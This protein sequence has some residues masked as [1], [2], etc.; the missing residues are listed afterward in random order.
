MEHGFV[1][2]PLERTEH[3]R[4][5][6]R[7]PVASVE[8]VHGRV[9]VAG[10]DDMVKNVLLPGS[11]RQLDTVRF[12]GFTGSA[13]GAE[14]GYWGGEMQLRSGQSGDDFLDI[15]AAVGSRLAGR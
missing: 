7:H 1:S 11:R 8:D 13:R 14:G 4:L 12:V 5:V 3:A 9:G 6:R 10:H 15:C 2:V